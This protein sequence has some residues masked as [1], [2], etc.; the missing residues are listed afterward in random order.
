MKEA[1][2]VIDMQKMF[3]KGK[4]KILMDEA[5]ENINMEINNF[6]KTGKP[7]IWIHHTWK[8][9]KLKK[10]NIEYEFID[11][12]KKDPNEICIEKTYPNSFKKTKLKEI[13]DKQKIDS[14]KLCGYRAEACVLFTYFGA[15]KYEYMV[16]IIKNGVASNSKLGIEIGKLFYGSSMI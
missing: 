7:V 8:F 9:G 15:K 13:L 16:S 5:S 12:L 11:L 6:R 4:T 14:L 3:Y 2:L 10:G 1:L